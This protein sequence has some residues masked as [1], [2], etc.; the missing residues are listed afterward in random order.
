ME[1]ILMHIIGTANDSETGEAVWSLMSA[2]GGTRIGVSHNKTQR[3]L[4]IGYHDLIDLAVSRGLDKPE[5]PNPIPT[6][7]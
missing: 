2:A 4:S 1:I 7:D 3:Q 6:E 5:A